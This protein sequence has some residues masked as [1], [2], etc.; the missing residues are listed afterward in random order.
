M[1]SVLLSCAYANYVRPMTKTYFQRCISTTLFCHNGCLCC[2]IL[3]GVKLVQGA[4]L[5]KEVELATS[6]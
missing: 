6:L 5:S 2:E 3:Y 1:T 4:Y